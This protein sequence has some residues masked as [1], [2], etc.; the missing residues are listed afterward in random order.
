MGWAS[1]KISQSQY[2]VNIIMHKNLCELHYITMH[3]NL[4]ELDQVEAKY[5][6]LC[7]FTEVQN[8]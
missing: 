4:C 1:Q 6:I 2:N 8:R 7:H 5:F 3:K